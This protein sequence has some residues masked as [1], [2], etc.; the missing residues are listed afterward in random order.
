VKEGS[1]FRSLRRVGF[2][3]AREGSLKA[4][5]RFPGFLG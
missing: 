1:G 3:M 4:S 2:K 5:G